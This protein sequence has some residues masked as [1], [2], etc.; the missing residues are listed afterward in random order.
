MTQ[1]RNV[2]EY[3]LVCALCLVAVVLVYFSAHTLHAN[4]E[5]TNEPSN[6]GTHLSCYSKYTLSAI[7][8]IASFLLF[9]RQHL[10]NDDCLKDTWEL[11]CAMLY[12]TV[13]HNDTHT[14]I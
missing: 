9:S 11:F 5:L 10:S 13:V 14:H 6:E 1:T 2:S 3:M 12:M 8:S 4:V 7:Y